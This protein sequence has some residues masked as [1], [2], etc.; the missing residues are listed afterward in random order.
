MHDQVCMTNQ[1]IFFITRYALMFICIFCR[2]I[3][4][5]LFVMLGKI[6]SPYKT[7][8]FTLPFNISTIIFLLALAEMNNIDMGP[9]RLPELP[10][11]DK[12]EVSFLTARAFF[13][14]S[15]RGVGQVFLANDIT[16]GILVLVGIMVCSRISALAAFVGSAIGAGVAA[17][18]GCDR[19]SIENGMYGFNPSLTLTAVTMFYVPSMGSM[20]IGIVAAI[21]TVFIQ[22]A[23]STSMSPTGLPF[24]TLPFCIAALAFIVIQGTTSNVISV[25]LSSM[26]SISAL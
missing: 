13:A 22:L 16:A 6:L 17:T 3:C 9:V 8:P 1:L 24:M 5:V 15:V 21:L 7:P 4:S 23:L 26:V 18:I 25:P 11:Y 20:L 14:G 2:Q 19:D 10:N 12:T